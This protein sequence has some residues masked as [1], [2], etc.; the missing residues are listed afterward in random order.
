[1]LN[2]LKDYKSKSV[3][4]N[5]KYGV[6]EN[7][8][9]EIDQLTYQ[10]IDAQ[11]V[12]DENTANVNALQKK[13][14]R[15]EGYLAT[16]D[17]NRASTLSNWNTMKQVVED[18][19]NLQ[20]DCNISQQTMAEANLLMQEVA[21]DVNT[22]MQELIYTAEVINNL[23][24][25]IVRKKAKNPLISDE[26]ITIL[27]DTG[28]D[29]NNAVALML[30]A[31]EST[32]TAQATNMEADAANALSLAQA[33]ALYDTLTGT[34]QENK[35]EQNKHGF[36]KSLENLI[37]QS[38]TNAVSVYKSYR[39]DVNITQ[40]QLNKAQYDLANAE[41]KLASLQAGLAAANA[42]A[43]AS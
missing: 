35:N 5:K 31:L 3:H 11:Y 28:K 36:G 33:D 30:T 17:T 19:K 15:F 27:G 4:L 13:L 43:L 37:Y 29:A 7:K 40:T 6:T 18:A 39:Q 8:K 14:T 16:A 9:A 1:M 12:V 21:I 20:K 32:F 34:T 10:V 38:Y 24:N 26:L 41:L 2:V 23:S 42:A 25:V 22:V